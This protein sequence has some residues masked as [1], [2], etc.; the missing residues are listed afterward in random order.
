MAVTR[1]IV[2]EGHGH[3]KGHISHGNGKGLGHQKH[4]QDAMEDGVYTI[5][6]SGINHDNHTPTD[7]TSPQTTLADGSKINTEVRD[8]SI[9]I[10]SSLHSRYP[11]A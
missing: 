6:I 10:D 8:G 9:T 11:A 2:E 3:G 7:Q 1:Y 5:K 4:A